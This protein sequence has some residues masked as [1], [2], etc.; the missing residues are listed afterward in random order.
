MNLEFLYFNIIQFNYTTLSKPHNQIHSTQTEEKLHPSCFLN[1]PRSP[2][3]HCLKVGNGSSESRVNLS[4]EGDKRCSI[5][6]VNLCFESSEQ[7]I[8]IR[9]KGLES[10]KN[11]GGISR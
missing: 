10:A 8:G 2:F 1:H 5:S 9:G 11:S 4:L 6:S 3:L 7:C